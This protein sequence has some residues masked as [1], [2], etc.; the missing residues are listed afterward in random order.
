MQPT[1]NGIVGKQM[2]KKDFPSWPT[3]GFEAVFKGRKYFSK[4]IEKDR[5]FRTDIEDAIVQRQ[6]WQFFT[7]TY[8]R[9]T[10]GDFKIGAPKTVVWDEM[11][12]KD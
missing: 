2:D 8:L 12:L 11:G 9:F 3:R 5:F 4:V 1:L 10:D 6:K 7:V